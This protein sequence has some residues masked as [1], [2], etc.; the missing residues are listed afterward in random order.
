M[1]GGWKGDA[2]V[3][4]GAQNKA[5]AAL[6]VTQQVVRGKCGAVAVGAEN[7]GHSRISR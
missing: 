1:L 3:A 7:V 6:A 2:C 5:A 4:L